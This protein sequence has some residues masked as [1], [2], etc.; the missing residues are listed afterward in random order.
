MDV[1]KEFKEMLKE[2]LRELKS[3]GNLSLQQLE[4]VHKIIETIKYI[5]DICE[6]TKFEDEYS[7]RYMRRYNDM[8]SGTHMPIMDDYGESS[9]RG[10]DTYMGRYSSYGRDRMY[11]RDGGYSREGATSSMIERLKTMMSQAVDER[12][13]EAIRGCIEKLQW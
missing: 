9:G 8:Y 2:D 3:K 12:E 1:L 11:S 7:G 4:V 13:R 5:E 6:K 10:Y